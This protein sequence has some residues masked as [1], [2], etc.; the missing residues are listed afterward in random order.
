[1]TDTDPEDEEFREFP[2][3]DLWVYPDLVLLPGGEQARVFSDWDRPM[4]AESGILDLSLGDIAEAFSELGERLE[5]AEEWFLA[6]QEKPHGYD[7][8][9][10]REG[11]AFT[12]LGRDRIDVIVDIDGLRPYYDETFEAS[13]SDLLAPMLDR[14]GAQMGRVLHDGPWTWVAVRLRLPTAGRLGADLVRFAEEARALLAA[15]R[16]GPL[17][18]QAARDLIVAGH[19]GALVGLREGIWLDGKGAPYR[20]ESDA[21]K[22]EL[23]RD[24]SA[25]AN[26]EGG[27]LVIPATTRV[28]RNGEV[29]DEVRDL[30][31]DLVDVGQIR[32]VLAEWIFPAIVGLEVQTVETTPGRGRLM[33]HVPA[34]P[35]EQWPYLVTRGPMGG[36]VR[37]TAMSICVRHDAEIR[38]VEAAAIHSWLQAG[39]RSAA[40]EPETVQTQ[41]LRAQLPAPLDRLADEAEAAGYSIEVDARELRITPPGQPTVVCRLRDL[42]PTTL[43]LEVTRLC[44]ALAAHG[45][46][47]HRTSRGFLRPGSDP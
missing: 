39:Q 27:L 12:P 7:D 45:M 46:P 44:E 9:D 10:L 11:V 17:D 6:L 36:R 29:I 2:V 4:V 1:M 38:S 24:T 20:L 42:H 43:L 30:D 18:R 3:G 23:A 41:V 47:T 13:V 15:A 26:A 34:Q 35:P 5:V 31:L 33:I 8:P 28:E 22:F 25:F 14:W 16:R 40:L 21:E 19:A 32:D 37:A